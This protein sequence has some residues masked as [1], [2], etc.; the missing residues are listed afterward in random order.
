MKDRARRGLNV[1]Q[2]SLFTPLIY[3]SCS[4]IYSHGEK[5]GEYEFISS[6]WTDLISPVTD[7]ENCA[8][9]LNR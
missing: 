8:S 1:E 2:E 5:A 3:A 4:P 7:K 9:S 6:V